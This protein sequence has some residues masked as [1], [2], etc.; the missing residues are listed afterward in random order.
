MRRTILTGDRPTGALH[1][2]HSHLRVTDPGRV[3]GNPVFAYLDAFDPDTSA[4]AE[5]KARYRAGGLGDVIPKR[6]LTEVIETFLEPIRTRRPRSPGIS[7]PCVRSCA[8]ARRGAERGRR[9]P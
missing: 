8:R 7:S 3:E 6:R 2:G 4:V 1:L 5:L 9:A